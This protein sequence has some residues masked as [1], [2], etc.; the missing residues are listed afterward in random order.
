M[1]RPYLFYRSAR[2]YA[3]ACLRKAHAACRG[4]FAKGAATSSHRRVA[5]RSAESWTAKATGSSLAVA[6]LFGSSFKLAEVQSTAQNPNERLGQS[7]ARSTA[8]EE[9]HGKIA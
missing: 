1:G 9:G 7:L 6:P 3:G 2:I 8:F 5:Q 4:R